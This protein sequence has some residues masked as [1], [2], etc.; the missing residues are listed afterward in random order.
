MIK[1]KI[2]YYRW[3]SNITIINTILYIPILFFYNEVSYVILL[4]YVDRM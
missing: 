2:P 4:S 1:V 3:F